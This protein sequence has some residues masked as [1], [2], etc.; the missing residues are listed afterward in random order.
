MW[1]PFVWRSATCAGVLVA[2]ALTASPTQA[3][4]DPTPTPDVPMQQG[5]SAEARASFDDAT[6]AFE[7]GDYA[8]AAA[9][10]RRAYE[11]TTHPDL[12][13][14][15]YTSLE[16]LSGRE[17][18]A[19]EA[20]SQYLDR[21]E[22]P[23]ER[24]PALEARLARLQARAA[25]ARAAEA[26]RA[27]AEAERERQAAERAAAERAAAEQAAAERARR[28]Q[29]AESS[30]GV[31]PA[32]I[33]VLVGAGVLL[34]NFGVF[35]ALSE[36]EDDRLASECGVDRPDRACTR[37]EVATLEAYN[38]VADVSWIAGAAAGVAGLILLLALPAETDGDSDEVTLLPWATP[39]A[40]GVSLGGRL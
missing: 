24:R 6:Q 12:L 31:H 34:A 22:V 38:L 1:S 35:A 37:D 18:E 9:G 29:Q 40:A 16:R 10:F 39:Q 11:L 33:G 20:L 2:A 4:G 27:R 26:E 30:G 7:V 21:G 36:V 14:N 3:Q 8:R 23:A 28:A 13:Y 17:E 19:A 25:E 5:A 32:S 15:V